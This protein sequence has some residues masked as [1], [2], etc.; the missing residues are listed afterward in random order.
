MPCHT[1]VVKICNFLNYVFFSLNP[2]LVSVI[3]KGLIFYVQN[4]CQT[5]ENKAR[6]E[7]YLINLDTYYNVFTSNQKLTPEDLTSIMN[8]SKNIADANIEQVKELLPLHMLPP[9]VLQTLFSEDSTSISL[10]I[11]LLPNLETEEVTEA[12]YTIKETV[13]DT[14]SNTI[15]YKMTRPE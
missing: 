9:E 7:Y 15:T 5:Y 3:K 12:L 11:T 8:S 1:F 4:D 6:N 13:R 10:P 2:T 14:V